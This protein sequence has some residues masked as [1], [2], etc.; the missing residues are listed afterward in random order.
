MQYVR[1]TKYR[2]TEPFQPANSTYG[3][4]MTYVISQN[5]AFYSMV[6]TWQFVWINFIDYFISH[7]RLNFSCLVWVCICPLISTLF[8]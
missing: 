8:G 4:Q 5:M 1:S 2:S 3:K 6:S 7:S